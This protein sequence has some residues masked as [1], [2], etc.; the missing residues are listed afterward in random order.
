MPTRLF[1]GD[2]SLPGDWA[3]GFEHGDDY[4]FVQLHFKSKDGVISGTYDA[5]LL[6]QQGRSLKQVSLNAS[7]I[8]FEFPNQPETRRFTGEIKDGVLA[9]RMKEG[10]TER[11]FRFTHLAPVKIEKYVGTYKIEPDHFSFIRNGPELGLDALQ[12]IDFKTGRFSVLFPTSDT[13]FFTGP[14]LLV[15]HPVE[16]TVKLSLDGQG[17]ATEFAWS[18]A[19]Q[20]RGRRVERR[21]EEVTFT[22]GNVTLSGT[23]IFPATPPP[24]PVIVYAAGGS[25]YGTREMFRVFA[26]FLALHGVA[27]LIYDKR[28]LGSS[29]GDWLRAGF[30]ELADDALAGV[31]LVKARSDIDAR[32]IG[33]MGASQ[34]GWIVALAAARSRDVAFIVSQSGSGV[35]VEEQELYRSEAW[36]RADGF[37]E[38]DIR[39]AMKFIRRRY[40]CAVTGEGWDALT[41]VEREASKKSWFA[42]TGG[43]AGKDNPFWGFWR[44][45]HNFDPVPVLE[46]VQCPVLAVLGAKDTFVPAEKSARIWQAALAKAGNKDVTIKVFPDGDHSL[47]ACKTGGLKET[48]RARG[49]VPGY[50][51]TLREWTQKQTR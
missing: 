12:C 17:R 51:D 9:G 31:R 20:F 2:A 47:I 25:I 28:G 39:D 30:D 3:G 37:S 41:E 10:A 14:A 26:E 4:V 23:L 8:T 7:T 1:A 33:L 43:H 38:E 34:S 40:Q 32:H 22:N 18:G 13:D 49:F 24:H 35:G 21:Q 11:A 36:L 50:F 42:Y 44:L 6:L 19:H 5:P 45:I 16:A 27:G 48:A 29:T 46:K 15:P